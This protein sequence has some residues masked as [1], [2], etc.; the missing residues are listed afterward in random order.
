MLGRLLLAVVAF[1][2]GYCVFP[3]VFP[4]SITPV[5]GERKVAIITGSSSGIG[6]EMAIQMGRAG[7]TVVLAARRKA[8]LEVVAAQVTAAGAPGVLPLVADLGQAEDC[9]RVVAE[10]LAAFGRL[11][12]LV[13]NHA[14]FDDGL[15]IEKDVAALDATLLPQFKVNVMGP[16]Y[17]IRA[18][19]PSL[20]KAPGGGS[21]VEVSSGSIRIPVPFHVR[22]LQ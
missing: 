20:E 6:A 5:T 13:I 12:M 22:P 3:L 4:G 7:Y 8:E 2:A 19:L 11:D 15:F 14:M 16:A 1:L 18:A 21:V 17:L 10:A 9:E